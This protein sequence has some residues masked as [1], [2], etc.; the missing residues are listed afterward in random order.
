MKNRQR[1][2]WKKRAILFLI[3]QC[4]TLFGSTLV[5][6]ALVWYATMQTSSG[7]WVASFTICSY[8]PQFFISFLGGIWA[9]RYNRKILIASADSL[10]AFVTLLMIFAIPLISSNT[11]LLPAL[12]H[13]NILKM[14]K[15][16][17]G[18]FTKA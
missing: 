5:Q 16:C 17:L 6:M 1:I 4:I 9:D 7:A 12:Y 11:A 3:S 10:I 2:S 8:L 18:F 15:I 13:P 14:L